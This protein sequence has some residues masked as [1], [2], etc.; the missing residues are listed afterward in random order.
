MKQ[1]TITMDMKEYEALEQIRKE[2]YDAETDYQNA[3]GYRS[4]IVSR[5][6]E[7]ENLKELNKMVEDA[8]ENLN[9]LYRSFFRR[10]DYLVENK[11]CK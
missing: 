7:M 2:I 9:R 11:V 4:R 8:R 3:Y 6:L 1:A 5:N 10:V